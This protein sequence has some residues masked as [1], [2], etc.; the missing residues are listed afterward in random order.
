MSPTPLLLGIDLGTSAC[1]VALI[2]TTGA[3]V[4]ETEAA[5]PSSSPQPLWSEQ[6]PRDWWLAAARSIRGALARVGLNAQRIAGVGLTGQMHGLVVLDADGDVLRP[7]ILWNDQR[8]QPQCAQI[9]RLVGAE[10]LLELTGNIVLPGFTL[11]KLLW[12]RDHEPSIYASI[13]HVLLPKDF[14]RYCLTGRFATDVSDASGT[15][16]FDVARRR[17]SDEMLRVCGAER[18]RLPEALESTALSG[19]ITPRSAAET[20]LSSGT[21]VFAGAGDQAAAAVGA[22]VVNDGDTCVTLGTSGVVFTAMRAHRVAPGGVLHAFCHAVPE[23]WHMMGVM[24]SAGGSL[25]WWRDVLR[26]GT[27]MCGDAVPSVDGDAPYAAMIHAAAGVTPG[28]EGLLFLPYLTGERTPHADPLA[29]GAFVGLTARH[30]TAHMTRA[31]LEGVA[32]GLCDSLELIRKT[33]TRPRSV[34]LSGGGARSAVWRQIMADIFGVDV[35]V[36]HGAQGGAFGAA[37]LAGVGAGCFANVAEACAAACKTGE[38]TSPG[39]NREA[40]RD[41]YERFRMLYPTLAPTFR[42]SAADA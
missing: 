16:M 28:C 13:A 12:V 39:P 26:G 24:L 18:A 21:P 15:A 6:N 19:T 32:F 38:T 2:D 5:Y 37:L 27:A 40:Y 25:R 14:I 31:V 42:S 30:A 36:A 17:W 8:T 23:T 35:I 34:R 41:A 22:G 29:R 11:P 10:R 20:G 9:T 3:T 4:A 33:G 7:A 1:K